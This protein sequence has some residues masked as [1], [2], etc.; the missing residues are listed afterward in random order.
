MKNIFLWPFTWYQLKFSQYKGNLPKLLLR[1]WIKFL[2][3]RLSPCSSSRHVVVTIKRGKS[4]QYFRWS[5]GSSFLLTN[6]ELFLVRKEKKI[7]ID[8]REMQ[9]IF[10][11]IGSN[12]YPTKKPFSTCKYFVSTIKTYVRTIYDLTI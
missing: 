2:E 1:L 12:S 8:W 9:V 11:D 10:S 4:V 6:L 7:R 3:N 5:V